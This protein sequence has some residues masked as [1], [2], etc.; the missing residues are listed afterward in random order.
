MMIG[1]KGRKEDRRKE[2]KRI[3]VEG[4]KER[5]KCGVIDVLQTHK[6]RLIGI[7]SPFYWTIELSTGYPQGVKNPCKIYH[8]L[9]Y[10][11][12]CN[13]LVTNTP[14]LVTDCNFCFQVITAVAIPTNNRLTNLTHSQN[15]PS[16][17][18]TFHTSLPIHPKTFLSIPLTFNL[19]IL[20]PT[21]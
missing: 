4:R 21:F 19:L 13:H 8:Y 20:L 2:G 18:H 16:S 3:W 6:L 12:L 7:F 17:L 1:R 15:F 10:D 14:G 9:Y 11:I 5:Y